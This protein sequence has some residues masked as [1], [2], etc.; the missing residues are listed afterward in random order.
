[1]SIVKIIIF[2]CL[3]FLFSCADRKKAT[4]PETLQPGTKIQGSI[5]G[6]L[7]QKNSP[8]HVVGDIYIDSLNSLQI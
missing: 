2:C 8:F 7:E 1:M 5:S 4:E 3:Y 6:I